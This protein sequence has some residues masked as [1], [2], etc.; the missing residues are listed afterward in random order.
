MSVSVVSPH[1]G[2]LV[3]R[4]LSDLAALRPT[5]IEVLLTN[6]Y[7]EVAGRITESRGAVAG[8]ASVVIFPADPDKWTPLTSRIASARPDQQGRFSVKGL[9]AGRYLAIALDYLEE[10]EEHDPDL[11]K[12]WARVAT[13]FTLGDGESRTID[14]EVTQ[15]N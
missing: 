13:T 9:Q 10:G 8:D 3:T 14:L 12:E 2:A 7:S 11:L 4:F 6:R 1:Q 15:A 5:D